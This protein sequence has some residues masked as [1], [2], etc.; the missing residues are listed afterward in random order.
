MRKDFML[1]M[2]KINELKKYT[3]TNV[4]K[5]TEQRLS[6]IFN[7]FNHI[8]FSL[9]GGKDSG[10]M[11]QLAN[12]VAKKMN[13][14]FDLFIVDIEA[15]YTSTVEF[16]ERM[17][18]LSNVQDVYHFCLPFFEDNNL[19]IFQPQ[20][21][22]WNPQEEEKW[23]QVMPADAIKEADLEDELRDI[24]FKSN[25]NPDR[26]MRYFIY[27]YHQKKNFEPVACG[28]GIRSEES[29]HRLFSILSHKKKYHRI[30][31]IKNYFDDTY[32]FYPI[33]DWKVEDIWGAVSQ[34]HLDFNLFYEQSYKMGISLQQMRI[35]QPYGLQQR[36]SLQQFATIE[37]ELWEKVVNRVS[38]V[39]FGSLYAKTSLLGHHHS[40]KPA[41]LTWQAYAVY[42]LETMGLTSVG[43]RDHY[44]RK[45]K[46]LMAY[47]KKKFGVEVSDM[48]DE[49]VRKEWLVD[50]K[51]W[52]DW[53]GIARAL[54]KNDFALTT[55]DYTLTKED[56]RELYALYYQFQKVTGVDELE[57]KLYQKIKEE[58]L[59]GDQ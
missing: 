43:L 34:L 49:S 8:Y 32:N 48:P 58:L 33:Y 51:L 36:K 2:S 38:G 29:I 50:E 45:I 17:K 27:W 13:K 10:L 18:K 57:G 1:S 24:F 37:P 35:C 31:W 5:A 7:E 12:Q 20:W 28:I 56:E 14:T 54:E 47:Y 25:G 59:G 9:S 39:N 19:S 4:L 40:S 16:I 46:I 55:R 52:H 30:S 44:Y 3:K 6:Y 41:H 11:V 15:N 21:M 23:I 42:L 53:K 26:F 22:M